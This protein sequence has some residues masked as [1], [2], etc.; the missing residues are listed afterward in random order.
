MARPITIGIVS[1][2][3]ISAAFVTASDARQRQQQPRR[4]P[5]SRSNTA[6]YSSFNHHTHGR[7]SDYASAR[8]LNCDNC[9]VIFSAAE[10]D[11]IADSHKPAIARGYPYHD[12]CF[13]C[14]EREIYRGDRP[15]I[16]TVCHTRV[17]PRATAQD[18]YAQFP[19]QLDISLR[20]FPGYFPHAPHRQVIIAKNGQAA[21]D[22]NRASIIPISLSGWR[23]R[24]PFVLKRVTCDAC[25]AT[26]ERPPEPIA[27]AGVEESFKPGTFKRS[28]AAPAAHATC[29]A[30]GCHWE[31]DE[32]KPKRDD[33]AGCHLTPQD[34]G[35]KRLNLLLPLSAV[36]F[37]E[38]PANWPKRVSMKFRHESEDHKDEA[39]K[40]CHTLIMQKPTLDIPDVPIASCAQSACHIK[41]TAK[42]SITKEMSRED[43]DIFE[44]RN[45]NPLSTEGKHTCT[46]CHTPVIGSA[47][48]PCSHYVALGE[49]GKTLVFASK[50]LNAQEYPKSSRELAERCRK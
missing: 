31:T 29:F 47:P 42:T 7:D 16:C 40:T 24:S 30:A 10:P 49:D 43:E 45:N 44:G 46:G 26:D 19:K 39:C 28:P 34:F 4:L 38:W 13:A 6:K 41:P 15:A 22:H 18:V 1:A 36:W 23:E 5:V 37:K 8:H 9:H 33:C 35:Q 14:H 2:L 25:H 50:Y 48:P 3:C 17:S 12:S 32:P 27:V 20:Q 21:S 11:R